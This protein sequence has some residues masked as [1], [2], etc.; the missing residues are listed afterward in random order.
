M[1]LNI[2]DRVGYITMYSV[3]GDCG[4]NYA[5]C[6]TEIKLTYR[7]KLI[8]FG[9]NGKYRT[10]SMTYNYNVFT[11]TSRSQLNDHLV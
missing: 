11:Y 5:G 9:V 4:N 10:L 3:V 7:D 1:C 8:T 6:M 2:T